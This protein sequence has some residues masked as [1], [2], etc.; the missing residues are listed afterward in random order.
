MKIEKG[1]SSYP[2]NSSHAAEKA[3]GDFRRD[4]SQRAFPFVPIDLDYI[5][6]LVRFY[7]RNGE[8][9]PADE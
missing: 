7:P 4:L 3:A 1:E 6:R 5:E 2:H 9:I 8:H